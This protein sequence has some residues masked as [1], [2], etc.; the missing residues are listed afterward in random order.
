MRQ[1]W[2]KWTW[3]QERKNEMLSRGVRDWT[4][5]ASQGQDTSSA[6]RAIER[7]KKIG[8]NPDLETDYLIEATKE[9]DRAK[10]DAVILQVAKN[11]ATASIGGNAK[12]K[13]KAK[14]DFDV[15]VQS[16]LVAT[17][18]S[19]SDPEFSQSLTI[20]ENDP[21]KLSKQLQSTDKL[22]QMRASLINKALGLDNSIT[23]F[24]EAKNTTQP[25]DEAIAWIEGAIKQGA[26]ARK[27]T[28]LFDDIIAA[29]PGEAYNPDGSVHG[30]GTDKKRQLMEL[31]EA[32]H[33]LYIADERVKYA[34]DNP[35]CHPA[36]KASLQDIGNSEEK[37]CPE[38]LWVMHRAQSALRRGTPA[39]VRRKVIEA[40]E[41]VAANTQFDKKTGKYYYDGELDLHAFDEQIQ[42]SYEEALE[43]AAKRASAAKTPRLQEGNNRVRVANLTNV[44]LRVLEASE[45]LG[46]QV[47]FEEVKGTLKLAHKSPECQRACRSAADMLTEVGITELE[48]QQAFVEKLLERHPGLLPVM[49]DVNRTMLASDAPDLILFAENYQQAVGDGYLD[50]FRHQ[51]DHAV[52]A[53]NTLWELLTTDGPA[54]FSPETLDQWFDANAARLWAG[55]EALLLDAKRN[56]DA[57]LRATGN[58]QKLTDGLERIQERM[59]NI[60]SQDIVI[61][62]SDIL[63]SVRE[64]GATL[65]FDEEGLVHHNAACERAIRIATPMLTNA[66]ITGPEKQKAFMEMLLERH[67]GALPAMGF[68]FMQH[69]EKTAILCDTMKELVE[70]LAT[71]EKSPFFIWPHSLEAWFITNQDMLSACEETVLTVAKEHCDTLLWSANKQQNALYANFLQDTRSLIQERQDAFLFYGNSGNDLG[72]SLLITEDP[73]FR[74]EYDEET[75]GGRPGSFLPHSYSGASGHKEKRES[76][77]KGKVDPRRASYGSESGEEPKSSDK[78]PK[79]DEVEELRASQGWIFPNDFPITPSSETDPRIETSTFDTAPTSKNKQSSHTWQKAVGRVLP[80]LSFLN[81][82]LHR[83]RGQEGSHGRGN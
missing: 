60:P 74:H 65:D 6:L 33:P 59:R 20:T 42:Q 24:T 77:G 34:T 78:E 68:D 26:D 37:A 63:S 43:S 73:G 16:N 38:Q 56:T 5:A 31:L 41:L 25:V 45:T 23:A 75:P 17:S 64:H 61:T 21:D 72:T 81:N 51:K 10:C 54:E 32:K 27:Y 67:P 39:E 79:R 13:K 47:T 52:G 53:Y 11:D 7:A 1:R 29:T 4:V 58:N 22:L 46:T 28:Y 35:Y 55:E 2:R 49:G 18:Y 82:V 76:K 50:A 44:T 48:M 30:G 83:H 19:L 15:I 57:V 66:G 3:S 70:D 36:L 71:E 8:A 12:Q 69:R 9:W 80:P 40:A 62:V 14:A